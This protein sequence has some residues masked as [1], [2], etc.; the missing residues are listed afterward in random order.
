LN[1]KRL[2]WSWIWLIYKSH[3]IKIF[4]F[5]NR[6]TE[7]N[8]MLF[9]LSYFRSVSNDKFFRNKLIILYS[10]IY[11]MQPRAQGTFRMRKYP[12]LVLRGV[13]NS[14]S[15]V[16]SIIHLYSCISYI[17]SL[18]NMLLFCQ[19]FRL[20]EAVVVCIWI[21]Y[22]KNVSKC[23]RR[24]SWHY[25]CLSACL[26]SP[27]CREAH[28]SGM[29]YFCVHITLLT[30]HPVNSIYFTYKRHEVHWSHLVM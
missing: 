28:L 11:K 22:L 12:N 21:T 4:W 5:Q 19:T 24:C 13:E 17:H 15:H 27:V 1:S 23:F 7:F 14:H 30:S 18:V 9:I 26:S 16:C 10:A 2:D 6:I 3:L 29:N 8:R 20:R 25:H